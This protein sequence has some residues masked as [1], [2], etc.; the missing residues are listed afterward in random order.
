MVHAW[1]QTMVDYLIVFMFAVLVLFTLG[2]IV[3]HIVTTSNNIRVE[4]IKKRI[5]R[6]LS[7]TQD[8]EFLSGQI[9]QLL[10]PEGEISSLREIR[11]ICSSRG[12]MAMS[13]VV[14]EVDAGKKE[15]LR[16]IILQDVWYQ[17]Y[18]R[19]SLRSRNDDRV[20]IV[21]KLV[22]ELRL[23]GFEDD[24]IAN[25]HRWT[26]HA[27]NQ[28]ISLLALFF[29][30]CGNELR[31]LFLEPG[32]RLILSFRSVLE[33]FACYSGDH[34]ELYRGLLGTDCDQYIVRACVRGI[35]QDG[36]QDLC[37]L[38]ETYLKADNSNLVIDAIRTLGKLHYAPATDAV[39]SYTEHAEWSVRSVAVTALAQIDPENCYE[40]LLHCLCD[41][42]WWVRFHAAEALGKLLGHPDLL[43]EVRTLND[44][45]AFE[46]MRYILERNELLG[47]EVP[48]A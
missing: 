40:T 14:E 15:L 39:R 23:N 21:T 46:M 2:L 4:R 16:G 9:Y 31:S 8:L 12:I 45:F 5:M 27:D 32:F 3:L 38:V 11:G 37:P 30:G 47:E 41:R 29:C 1:I 33:L 20:G 10:D 13:I 42:E 25:L 28:E 35:G 36:L 7:V 34:G 18:I 19:K 17:Q 24:V 6:M 48:A 26:N 22:A 44:R 43:E